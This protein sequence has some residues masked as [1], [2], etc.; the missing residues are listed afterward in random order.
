MS[1]S[2][3]WNRLLWADPYDKFH[4][5]CHSLIA[6]LVFYPKYNLKYKLKVYGR[7]NI[8]SKGSSSSSFIIVSNHYSYEDPVIISLTTHKPIAYIAKQELFDD[9]KLSK[10]ITFL[11]A[12]PLNR[13]QTGHSTFKAAKQA[14]KA[15]WPLGIFIEG[16]RNQSRDE[17]SN[18]ERG[19]AF[20]ARMGG[21][22]QVLPLGIRG[23]QNKGD[24]L[25]VHIGKTIP[26]REGA[27]LEEQSIEYGKAVAELAGL[28][29]NF[30]GF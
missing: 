23:G 1:L 18:L 6:S 10:W 8:P 5:I 26:F 13:E 30:S 15:G 25:E 19:A 3:I 21:R 4:E 28:K 2:D 24:I 22:L 11:G 12:I 14:I 20:L 7:D 9:P 17:L 29:F 16:S 27:S